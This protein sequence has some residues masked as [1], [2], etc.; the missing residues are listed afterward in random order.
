M[1]L[2]FSSNAFRRNTIEETVEI[3]AGIGYDGLEIMCDV[4][5]AWPPDVTPEKLASLRR[6]LTGHR[7]GI[8]NL[9][10][11][12]MCAVG[13]FH[14]PSW[15][16]EDPAARKQRL[17][18]TLACIRL[19]R[20]LGAA[21]LSTEPGG[22]KDERPASDVLP[23]FRETIAP[24]LAEADR[25][26]VKVLVE[27]EPECT[28]ETSRQFLDFQ[29]TVPNRSFGLNCDIGH[30]YCVG[31]DPADVVRA[32]KGR[33]GHVHLEDIAADR[34]HHHL[35]P[36]DGAIDYRALFAALHETGYD[37]WITVE[38]YPFQENPREIA[39]RAYEHIRPYLG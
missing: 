35:V 15:I 2:A 9:N 5:H 17:D 11:F 22:P 18:H 34:K 6:A 8:S 39:R 21:T 31:E 4:P 33:I 26:G 10:A 16:E 7:M 19:A 32:M 25:A 38:L 23:L 30:F 27:P 28:I 12:M 1:R 36:G 14:R 24:A 3:L 29:K 20:E 37:G 13:D